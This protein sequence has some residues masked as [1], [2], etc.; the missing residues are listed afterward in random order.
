MKSKLLTL[1]TALLLSGLFSAC[2]EEE[3]NPNDSLNYETVGDGVTM[4]DTNF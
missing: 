2:A 1:F 4:D 3:I